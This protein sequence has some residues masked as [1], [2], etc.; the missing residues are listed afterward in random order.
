MKTLIIEGWRFLAHSYAL[1]N[2]WQLLS[3]SRRND[4]H[5]KVIDA[6]FPIARWQ[7]QPALFD[8]RSQRILSAIEL[9]GANERA[10]ATLRIISPFDFSRSASERTTVFGTCE[11]QT[12]RKDQLANPDATKHLMQSASAGI[13]VVTPSRWSADGFLRAGFRP[14]NVFIVP[15]GVD[16]DTFRPMPDIRSA[17]RANLGFGDDEFVFVT[18]GAMTGNKGIDLLI[19]AFAEVCQI[20]PQVRLVLKGMDPLYDSKGRIGRYLQKLPAIDR[21]RVAERLTYVGDSLSVGEMAK[22]FQ[23]A[24]AYVS[25]YRA[26][27]FNLPV[28]EA[29]ACGIPIACTAG[30]ATDD[31]VTAEFARRIESRKI[32]R[33]IDDQE[34]WHLEPDL[35]HLVATMESLVDDS[36]WRRGAHAAGPQHVSANYTWDRV[37]DV[38]VRTL[39]N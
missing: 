3:L 12:I 29:A 1:V 34:L 36:A 22:F 19:G 8:E 18:V 32:S 20:L 14:E 33:T 17:A 28:L 35:H 26:E 9:A 15:H 13:T 5:I 2:Q 27:G 24:D 16:V 21:D 4:V 39:L 11:S 38:L 6:P 7:R 30:G 23:I 10:D 37:V 31:F 25:P